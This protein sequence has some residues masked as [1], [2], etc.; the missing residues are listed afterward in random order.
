LK[1]N[2][3][4]YFPLYERNN[5]VAVYSSQLQRYAG[6]RREDVSYFSLFFLKIKSFILSPFQKIAREHFDYLICGCDCL[7]SLIIANNLSEKGYRALIYQSS[8]IQD[9]DLLN[10]VIQVQS[11]LYGDKLY[12]W[13]N[14]KFKPA[15]DFEKIQEIAI[16]FAENC[17]KKDK[18]GKPLVMLTNGYQYSANDHWSSIH[19]GFCELMEINEPK[20]HKAGLW[21]VANYY[22]TKIHQNKHVDNASINSEDN[23]LITFEDMVLTTRSSYGINENIKINKVYKFG[24]ALLN[25]EKRDFFDLNER[26]K[27]LEEVFDWLKTIKNKVKHE[28]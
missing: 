24:D 4:F 20:D 26:I 12:S 3:L 1:K 21:D 15:N 8:P 10:R 17:N 6:I 18:D 5:P 14:D 28:R 27:N 25:I 2:N 7:S 23:C 22:L 11:E 9:G 13:F 16:F 19:E